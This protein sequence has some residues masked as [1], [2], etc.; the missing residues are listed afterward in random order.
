MS[1]EELKARLMAEAEKAIDELIA[2]K[3][4]GMQITLADIERL[5]LKS[6]QQ[7][8]A[9]LLEELGQMNS[10]I[11]DASQICPRCGSRLQ[12]RGRRTRHLWTKA[13]E[14]SLERMYVVCPD[15]GEAFFPSGQTMG[16][17]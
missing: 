4:V 17:G 5:V 7:F 10:A 1:P 3:P 16:V 13:G 6:G 14:M 11:Q 9:G 15:C 2:T 8:Q 12:R